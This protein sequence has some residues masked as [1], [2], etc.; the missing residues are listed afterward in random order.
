MVMTD[1][2]SSGIGKGGNDAGAIDTVMTNGASASATVEIIDLRE[3]SDD[4]A[5]PAAAE[6]FLTSK[7][8]W[9]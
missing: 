8:Q 1:D 6:N 4:D 5:K 3:D 9:Q 7:Q 2:I